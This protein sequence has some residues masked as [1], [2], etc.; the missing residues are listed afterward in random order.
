MITKLTAVQEKLHL[1]FKYCGAKHREFRN[2]CIGM[3]PRI[4]EERIYEKTGFDSIG[5]YAGKLAGLSLAQVGLT[6]GLH[7]NFTDKPALK[8]ILETG[9]VGIGKLARIASIATKE[10]QAFLAEQVMLLSQKALETLVRDVREAQRAERQSVENENQLC[11]AKFSG[12]LFQ[13]MNGSPR[14]QNSHDFM[15]AHDLEHGKNNEPQFAASEIVEPRIAD[16]QHGE[17][18]PAPPLK[19]LQL[20]LSARNLEKLLELQEKGI[21]INQVIAEAVTSRE[22]ENAQEKAQLSAQAKPTKSRYVKVSIKKIIKKE[23]GDKCAKPGC[24]KPATQTH[25]TDRFAMSAIHDPHF[26]APLCAEHHQI[27]HAID[28]KYQQKQQM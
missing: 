27:A 4:L 6:L 28:V 20:K 24:Q 3:L 13:D 22:E 8:K 18:Q 1:E 5:K 2:K 19:L 26:M 11:P 12:Q 25:H 21:D 10:N 23:H 14:P 15:R 9:A 17:S 7:R 16:S